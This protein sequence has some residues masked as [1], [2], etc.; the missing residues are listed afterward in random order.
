MIK[1]SEIYFI[2]VTRIEVAAQ[3]SAAGSSYTA[4]VVELNCR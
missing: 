2:A 1:L 4:R 3:A